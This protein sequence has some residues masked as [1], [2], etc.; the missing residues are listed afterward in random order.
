M[1]TV[2]HSLADG[3][4]LQDWSDTNLISG[5]GWSGVPSITGGTLGSVDASVDLRDLTGREVPSNG[6][7]PNW[8]ILPNGNGVL[9]FEIADPTIVLRPS[10]E[11]GTVVGLG[12]YLDTSGCEDIRL[13][14][15]IRDVDPAARPE[16][17]QQL[18]VQYR[19]G[20]SGAW[21]NLEGGYFPDVSTSGAGPTVSVDLTLPPDA[22]D[23]PQVQIRILT[24]GGNSVSEWI[25]ID[26]IRVSR[27]DATA[28]VLLASSP[29][30]DATG[31]T[32][33][34]PI[35]LTFDEAVQAGSGTI[36]VMS[37]DAVIAAIDV[38]DAAFDGNRV[39]IDAQLEASTT[40]EV[41]LSAGVIRDLAGNDFAGLAEG[42]LTFTT[43]A[44]RTI[45]G[46]PGDDTLTGS[47]GDDVVSG[48]AGA[49]T[50][51][52]GLGND[53]VRDTL[54]AL[55]GDMISGFGSGDM[56]DIVGARHGR[57]QMSFAQNG[58]QMLV[59]IGDRSFTLDGDFSEG[60]FMAVSRGQGADMHTLVT[61]QPFLPT[62]E[63]GVRVD[64]ARINGVINELFLSGDGQT[65][66]TLEFKSAMSAY[67]NVLGCYKIGSDGTIGDVRILFD[68]TLGVAAG[69]TVDLGVLASGDSFG[70]FLVQDGFDLYGRLP[71]DLSFV[72]AGTTMLAG[73]GAGM[74]VLHSASL[75][76]LGGGL[77][78]HSIAT[79]NPDG[80]HQ[81][82]SGVSRGGLEL[83][84]G[85]ED[86]QAGVGDNDYQD[87]VFS[88][89]ADDLFS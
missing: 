50:I 16:G 47:D 62:L 41:V 74:P 63:E 23:E 4:F 54:D 12:L 48:G 69:Q 9:E 46:T 57:E 13:Q 25:G 65:Q 8:S 34:A 84:M 42:A 38:N 14:F 6:V 5:V 24:A 64:P 45:A 37:G 11:S 73:I 2:Y 82:L 60:D 55:H 75:G 22:N 53:I 3:E 77:V 21:S 31:A 20:S 33:P 19:V 80:A 15:D 81:V 26:N 66:F 88:I 78:F 68:N 28:P 18:I 87:V 59:T 32:F 51:D 29:A 52:L 61:F 79:L 70:F 71:D 43:S 56:L 67:A 27:P 36:F 10:A 1:S 76:D 17:D 72:G 44:S 39:V 30:N 35:V 49:D 58:D 7:S 40:Y 85:F 89:R 86:A 83:L